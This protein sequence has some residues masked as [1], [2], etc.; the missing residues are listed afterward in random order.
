M[1]FAQAAICAFTVLG[2]RPF[3]PEHSFSCIALWYVCLGNIFIVIESRVMSQFRTPKAASPRP[4][5]QTGHQTRRD[6]LRNCL[7]ISLGSTLQAKSLPKSTSQ[8]EVTAFVFEEDCWEDELWM[9]RIHN[10]TRPVNSIFATEA[11]ILTPGGRRRRCKRQAVLVYGLSL[12]R[13]FHVTACMKTNNAVYKNG[14]PYVWDPEL[15]QAL[16]CDGAL[17][18][19]LLA[20]VICSEPCIN[21]TNTPEEDNGTEPTAALV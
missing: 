4:K 18:L 8:Y 19:A 2:L 13:D 6:R 11:S 9:L 16:C 1:C 20:R 15:R 12:S 21:M 14:V 7:C 17:V 5:E 3:P 10:V